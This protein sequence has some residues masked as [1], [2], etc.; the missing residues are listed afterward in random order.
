LFGQPQL[1]RRD[2]DGLAIL[3]RAARTTN[4]AFSEPETLVKP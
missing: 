4:V 3:T 1:H 2:Q